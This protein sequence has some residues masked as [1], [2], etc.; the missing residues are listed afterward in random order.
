LFCAIGVLSLLPLYFITHLPDLPFVAVLAFFPA[1][2]VLMSGRM[3]PMQAL[4]TTV[5]E[6]AKRGAF[7]SLNSA[8]M[9]LGTGCGAWLGG[10]LLAN[11]ADGHITGYQN[12][13]LIAMA[14][15]VFGFFWVYQVKSAV[16]APPPA[17]LDDKAAVRA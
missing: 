13:G 3:V 10:L 15:A 16:E 1:F 2:M 9:S 6:P 11:A 8:T 7:L 17:R 5:P 14:I 4:L 12:N